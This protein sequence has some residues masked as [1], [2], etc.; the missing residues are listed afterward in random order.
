MPQ[1]KSLNIRT[2][3]CS[4]PFPRVQA[5]DIVG[6]AS[7]KRA[8]YIIENSVR[9]SPAE[10]LQNMVD[11]K[12]Q[13]AVIGEKQLLT[14]I[15]EYH[16]LLNENTD[17]GRPWAKLRGIGGKTAAIGEENLLMRRE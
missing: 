2:L 12:V 9:V 17:D 7:I 5:W 3:K 4:P 16:Y 15:P 14:D 6:P 13:V 11:G 10:I 8:K 1:R